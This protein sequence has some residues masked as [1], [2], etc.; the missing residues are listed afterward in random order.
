VRPCLCCSGFAFETKHRRGRQF[1]RP[2]EKQAKLSKPLYADV[3]VRSYSN[4][5][6]VRELTTVTAQHPIFAACSLRGSQRHAWQ[7]FWFEVK[8]RAVTRQNIANQTNK[9]GTRAPEVYRC[10]QAR[11]A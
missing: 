8:P 2:I 1:K 6:L 7:L 5:W 10:T 11:A 4:S 3:H 9:R